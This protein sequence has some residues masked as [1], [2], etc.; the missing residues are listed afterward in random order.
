MEVTRDVAEDTER[1]AASLS[2]RLDR[3]A[4]ADLPTADVTER[5]IGAVDAWA[6]EQGWRVY[7]RARSV[8]PLPPPMSRQP[9][10]LD[11]A[12]ARPAGPPIA[13]EVDHTDRRRTIDKLLAE[14]DAG[15]IPIWVRW[16][17]GGFVAPPHPVRMVTCRVTRRAS[18]Y[19]RV[20][21]A[22]PAH[23]PGGGEVTVV[24][25]PMP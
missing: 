7:R 17:T 10:V 14:A 24:A 11:V 6:S 8:M 25:L 16:G 2:D 3:L 18:L 19:S 1:V 13:I 22:P 4:F 5:I 21:L 23:S 12:C 9:S 20:L 15:R